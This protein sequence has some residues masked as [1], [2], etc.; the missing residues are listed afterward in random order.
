MLKGLIGMVV[1]EIWGII[2]E[3]IDSGDSGCG[4]TEERQVDG[5]RLT[6]ASRSYLGHLYETFLLSHNNN[7]GL[8]SRTVWQEVRT[9]PSEHLRG[10]EGWGLFLFS[11]Q[12]KKTPR[13]KA[14]SRAFRQV[15][16]ASS[17]AGRVKS[18]QGECTVCGCVY[19]REE[20]NCKVLK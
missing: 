10:A 6:W 13:R 7:A 12:E 11:E 8:P 3:L 5:G 1:L 20:E 16:E 14:N 17:E 9:G 2:W 18:Q 4:S 15:R 19:V